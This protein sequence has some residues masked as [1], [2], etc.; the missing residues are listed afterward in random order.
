MP[1]LKALTDDF[2]QS[3]PLARDP[4]VLL[5]F[6]VMMKHVGDMMTDFLPTVFESLC[7]STLVMI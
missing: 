7:A 5:L 6:S 3:D 2:Q 1:S 4:E